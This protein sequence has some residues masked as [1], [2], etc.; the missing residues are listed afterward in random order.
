MSILN[1]TPEFLPFELVVAEELIDAYIESPKE[2]GLHIMV[3]EVNGEIAGYVCYGHTPLTESTWDIYWIAVDRNRQGQG[4]GGSL[5]KDSENKIRNIGGKLVVVETSS[6]PNYDKTRRFYIDLHYTEI[7]RI[8][9]FYAP[10]DD[11]IIYIKRI[12]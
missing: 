9:D 12:N 4:I 10:N 8:P 2:S 11:E 3:A 6:K 1:N 7:A 5:M